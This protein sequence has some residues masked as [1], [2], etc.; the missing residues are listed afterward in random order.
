MKGSPRS[1]WLRAANRATGYWTSAAVAV[2][3][4]QQRAMLAASVNIG[5]KPKRKPARRSLGRRPGFTPAPPATQ[6]NQ[7][8]YSTISITRCVRGSTSTVRSFTTV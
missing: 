5:K 1:L 3:Q 7:A 8:S 6:Y 2:L 4:R